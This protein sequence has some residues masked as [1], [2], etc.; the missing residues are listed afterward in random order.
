M[1]GMVPVKHQGQLNFVLC[2]RIIQ[3]YTECFYTVCINYSG[4][5]DV[6][7]IKKCP[8][9]TGL[10]MLLSKVQRVKFQGFN[11]PTPLMQNA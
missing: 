8:W 1:Q 4:A 10:E 7:R 3:K 11:V 6:S 2:H 5:Q 9:N